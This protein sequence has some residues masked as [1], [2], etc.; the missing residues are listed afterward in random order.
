MPAPA[1]T[2][3]AFPIV[4]P[5][6]Q[7]APPYSSVV[8]GCVFPGGTLPPNAKPAVC[9]P[10]PAKEYLAPD[11]FPPLVQP[12]TLGTGSALKLCTLNPF[13]PL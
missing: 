4:P 6:A 7:V 11:K 1:K 2:A 5:L 10:A 9:I 12:A 3:L 8:P 13:I